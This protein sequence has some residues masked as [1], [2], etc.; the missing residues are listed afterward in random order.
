MYRGS[1]LYEVDLC[2]CSVTSHEKSNI[3]ENPDQST[4]VTVQFCL[5]CLRFLRVH[6]LLYRL[7]KKGLTFHVNHLLGLGDDSYFI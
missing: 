1:V 4:L 6:V 3:I 2:V 5:H 7:K